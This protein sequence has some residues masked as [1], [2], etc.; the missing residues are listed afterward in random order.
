MYQVIASTL[1][2]NKICRLPGI[3]TL[4]MIPHSAVTDFVNGRIKSP[5]ETIDFI[6][7]HKGDKVFNE[8][9]A[10]SELLQ[11]NLDVNKSAF[12]AGIGTFT[13]VRE[14]EIKFVPVSIDPVFTSPV[15]VKRVIRQ[16]AAHAILVGDQQTTN[17]EMTEFFTEKQLVKDN[18]WIWAT[19]LAMLGLG[20]LLFYYSQYGLKGIGNV[21]IF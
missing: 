19:I 10:M 14:G 5:F 16:D 3:G 13:K 20:V 1:F 4:V 9:S 15:P 6:P 8:F 11:K 12:L 21:T 2:Q 7:E 18:W 17:V